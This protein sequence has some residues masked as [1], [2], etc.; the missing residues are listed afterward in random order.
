MGWAL[1]M[2]WLWLEK[3]K[4]DRPWAGLEI[5]VHLNTTAMFAISIVTT[6]GNGK[7][8]KFWTDRWLHGSCLEDFG[9]KCLQM[10]SFEVKKSNN[11]E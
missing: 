4:P 11:C 7:N 2:R 8:T 5:P 10:C 6:I 3:T 9:L 1:Q